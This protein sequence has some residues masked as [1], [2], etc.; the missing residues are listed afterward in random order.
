MV[1]NTGTERQTKVLT[2]GEFGWV[3]VNVAERDVD[4]G[5]TS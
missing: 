1:E 5:G 2:L 4:G 3:V